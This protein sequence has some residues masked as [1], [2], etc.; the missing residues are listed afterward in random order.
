[1]DTRQVSCNL[2][3]FYLLNHDRIRFDINIGLL[4][5]FS[6]DKSH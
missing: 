1:M 2:W 3:R 6:T 5:R 4:F